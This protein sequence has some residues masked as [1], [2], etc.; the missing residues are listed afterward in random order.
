MQAR[1]ALF[2]FLVIILIIFFFLFIIC[3][4]LILNRP[5]SPHLEDPNR[6]NKYKTL[7]EN[8]IKSQKYDFSRFTQYYKPIVTTSTKSTRPYSISIPNWI[9]YFNR[10]THSFNY[11]TTTKRYDKLDGLTCG[12][13]S[14]L[15]Y[16]YSL[17][18]T[19][20]S[21][22]IIGGNDVKPN[23][24]P[25]IVSLRTV[26]NEALYD[27]FCGGVLI[28]LDRVLTAAHCVFKL[29]P[30]E[31]KVVVGLHIRT[32]ISDYAIKNTYNVEEI[33][34]NKKFNKTS[35]SNDIAILVLAKPVTLNQNISII[36]LP[37]TTNSNDFTGSLAIASG[38]GL[39]SD[40]ESSTKLQQ[41]L[42]TIID[43]QDYRCMANLNIYNR[44]MVFCALDT[45][46]KSDRS[47][48]CFGDSGGPL[49]IRDNNKWV[50]VGIISYVSGH[51]SADNSKYYCDNF[52]PSFFT[53]V[54][55][56]LEW[57]Y[58]NI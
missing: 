48:I 57:I 14:D 40:Y 24:H 49:V 19:K 16:S 51:I 9:N 25:W 17:T 58:A 33:I 26:K 47:S 20:T 37:T 2:W 4:F 27:H 55:Y 7:Y 38:W 12:N 42:L 10:L 46:G 56:F 6:S 11:Q 28:T 41:S 34:V 23:S 5:P 22:R 32:D 21:A 50:L 31:L 29:T 35:S 13:S 18:S 45:T 39:K 44:D 30:I 36:C 15:K 1:P 3:V 53:S 54:P 43:K 8:D 52:S